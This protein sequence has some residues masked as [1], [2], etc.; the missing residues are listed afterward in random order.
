MGTAQQSIDSYQDENES[1]TLC[2]HGA[3]QLGNSFYIKF[4]RNPEKESELVLILYMD[5]GSTKYELPEHPNTVINQDKDSWSAQ[6]L[7]MTVLEVDKRVRITFNGL[8]RKGTRTS[9]DEDIHPGLEH[10]RLNFIFIAST[11][12]FLSHVSGGKHKSTND[13]T[14]IDQYG[15]MVGLV[16]L[17]SMTHELYCRGMRQF[18]VGELKFDS[19]KLNLMGLDRMGNIFCIRAQV[20]NTELKTKKF[21]HVM[22]P[23]DNFHNIDS[24]DLNIKEFTNSIRGT[25]HFAT[26]KFK[27]D[28]TYKV[29]LSWRSGMTKKLFGGYPWNHKTR[30][31]HFTMELNG[32]KGFAIA[33]YTKPYDG[34]CPINIPITNS[35]R[36]RNRLVP[37]PHVSRIMNYVIDLSHPMCKDEK[38]VGGRGA[39][40]AQMKSLKSPKF[41]IPDGFCLTTNSFD[42]FLIYNKELLEA[43]HQL[44]ES[45]KVYYESKGSLDFTKEIIQQIPDGP[46]EEPDEHDRTELLDK[47]AELFEKAKL[48]VEILDEIH[49]CMCLLFSTQS[50][51]QWTVQGSAYHEDSDE[52]MWAGQDL[53]LL[54]VRSEDVAKAVIDCWAGL[55]K[56]DCVEYRRYCGLPLDRPIGLCIQPMVGEAD[57]CGSLF[58]R[59]PHTGDPRRVFI[60]SQS[61]KD[62]PEKYDLLICVAVGPNNEYE[63]ESSGE[64]DFQGRRAS[65]TSVNEVPKE[66]ADK[67]RSISVE[68]ALRLA[69]IGRELDELYG[70]AR[71]IDWSYSAEKDQI[72][73]QLCRPLTDFEAWTD[74]ELTHELGSGVPPEW[75]LF[76]YVQAA[77]IFPHPLTPLTCTTI[78]EALSPTTFS[79]GIR[80]CDDDDEADFDDERHPSPFFIVNMRVAFNHFNLMLRNRNETIGNGMLAVDYARGSRTPT[81]PELV[82]VAK[83]RIGIGAG[84]RIGQLK[85]LGGKLQ[86]LFKSSQPRIKQFEEKIESYEPE[87][88]MTE[89]YFL[90]DL[91]NQLETVRKVS[92]YHGRLWRLSERYEARILQLL[93]YIEDTI[94]NKNMGDVAQLLG[95][96]GNVASSLLP[97]I[98]SS[99]VDRPDWSPLGNDAVERDEN[100]LRI[101]QFVEDY[102]YR[103]VNELELASEPFESRPEMLF[104]ALKYVDPQA[105]GQNIRPHYKECEP[106]GPPPMEL[107]Q[108]IRSLITPEYRRTIA[109]LLPE[110]RRS[111]T[112]REESKDLLSKA[113]H[114]VRKLFGQ[115]AADLVN[116]GRLPEIGLIHYLTRWEVLELMRKD[117]AKPALIRKAQRRRRLWPSLDRKIH[118]PDYWFGWPRPLKD[119]DEIEKICHEYYP[120]Y[121]GT[122][123][124]PGKANHRVVVARTPDEASRLR[125]GDILVAPCVDVGWSQY[126]PLVA[127]IITEVGGP[128]SEGAVIA[129][130]NKIPCVMGVPMATWVFKTGDTLSM[131][132]YTGRIEKRSLLLSPAKPCMPKGTLQKMLRSITMARRS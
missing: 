35:S 4:Q 53:T 44:M 105:I 62:E 87:E 130:E 50:S 25:K 74:F 65:Q 29:E 70:S 56:K 64:V 15:S 72:H 23:L 115:K 33:E 76:S 77:E 51:G 34:T 90:T 26:F 3:D 42:R 45:Y 71:F 125:Q 73:L 128:L 9:V 110:A 52:T 95:C 86:N 79:S 117:A 27:A 94:T 127:G 43:I 40:L 108:E 37:P 28:K 67:L 78:C 17:E 124:C 60:G 116:A 123:I 1:R 36:R 112:R 22:D 83:R 85:L 47:I 101:C 54:N 6:G 80:S 104:R 131:N 68:V 100:W 118:H 97:K 16:R 38:L 12:P 91:D 20:E 92:R 39:S 121:N 57:S 41:V 120:A 32:T 98:I 69:E 49:V 18:H 5:G 31:L 10:V 48:P 58:T 102:G 84:G 109:K 81:E 99:L 129:R 63:I 96:C 66:R 2:Y 11:K 88:L 30:Y 7:T 89:A 59:H 61:S 103:G 46:V 24:S 82:N 8:L 111:V 19:V 114:N 132:G 107:I 126:F 113:V 119:D 106:E 55:F 14:E 21:G 93:S 13:K 75:D 122:P